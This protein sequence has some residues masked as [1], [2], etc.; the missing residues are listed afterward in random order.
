MVISDLCGLLFSQKGKLY[1]KMLEAKQRLNDPKR[2]EDSLK[3]A[4]DLAFTNK[5]LR[6]S[7][8]SSDPRADGRL[9]NQ[10]GLKP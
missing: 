5:D 10:E 3:T 2:L 6:S 4:L 8:M 7:I 9:G 1:N